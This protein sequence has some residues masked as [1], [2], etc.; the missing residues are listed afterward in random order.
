MLLPSLSH[1]L[2]L[3]LCLSFCLSLSLSRSLPPLS[4]SRPFV[5]NVDVLRTVLQLWFSCRL[6][7]SSVKVLK[8]SMLQRKQR[9]SSHHHCI[10]LVL[11]PGEPTPQAQHAYSK[12]LVGGPIPS[13]STAALVLRVTSLSRCASA[14][15]ASSPFARHGHGFLT[16]CRLFRRSSRIMLDLVPFHR[17]I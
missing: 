1:P 8:P 17:H 4:P 11:P 12:D 16:I 14:S 7:R 13:A 9:V 15:W 3:C 6:S 10:P 5:Y 2:C